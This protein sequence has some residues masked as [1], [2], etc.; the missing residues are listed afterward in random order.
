MEI[1]LVVA[2]GP[3][4]STANVSSG[5]M[6]VEYKKGEDDFGKLAHDAREEF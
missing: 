2:I 1:P 4:K 6:D 5:Y 3:G